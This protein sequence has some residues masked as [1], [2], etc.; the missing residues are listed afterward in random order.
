MK[1][2]VLMTV[3]LACITA[4]ATTYSTTFPGT[5]NPISESGNWVN[6]GTTG[7]DV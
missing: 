6:G 3:V 1:L 7:L 5:E 4:G 2:A